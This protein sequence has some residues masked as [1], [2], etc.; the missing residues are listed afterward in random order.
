[1][2]MTLEPSWNVHFL[3]LDLLWVKL[4]WMRRWAC[5]L[6]A[7][8]ISH[9]ASLQKAPH[10]QLLSPSC[11]QLIARQSS[12][13]EENGQEQRG[14]YFCTNR[15]TTSTGQAFTQTSWGW[16][17]L[18]APDTEAELQMKSTQGKEAF[19][20]TPRDHLKSPELEKGNLDFICS[21]A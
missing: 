10:R 19:T 14:R 3:L 2:S 20:E 18:R 11:T 15:D 13:W 4:G 1:M 8:E 9:K 5:I 21:F 16:E 6:K 7:S 12:L 17:S